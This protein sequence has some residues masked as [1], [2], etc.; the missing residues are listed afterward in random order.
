MLLRV[1]LV[2]CKFQ[3]D[4]AYIKKNV[5]FLSEQYQISVLYQVQNSIRAYSKTKIWVIEKKT[6]SGFVLNA[7][8]VLVEQV[9]SCLLNFTDLFLL[10]MTMQ[11]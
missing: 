8:Q 6:N 2:F 4:V 11:N 10:S 1:C 3:L 7:L 9:N 5:H